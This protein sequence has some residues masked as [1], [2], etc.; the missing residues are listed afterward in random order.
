MY[1]LDRN[2]ITLGS[3]ASRGFWIVCGIATA[4]GLVQHLW[5]VLY[6]SPLPLEP[7]RTERQENGSWRTKIANRDW[8]PEKLPLFGV[9]LRVGETMLRRRAESHAE[10]NIMGLQGPAFFLKG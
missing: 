5:P 8:E 7:R 3:R 2:Q 9:R 10:L 1:H 6:E 4:M